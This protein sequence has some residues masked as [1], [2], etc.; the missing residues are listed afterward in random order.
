MKLIKEIAT[1]R[2]SILD[3]D[4][5]SINFIIEM[6]KHPDNRDFI[7][8]GT[9]EEHLS[10]INDEQHLLLIFQRIEDNMPI[11]YSLSYIIPLYSEV[12]LL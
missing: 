2:L 4:E 9:Y 5:S 6:E 8:T 1:E 12:L 3:A 10:E 7:W 11:G